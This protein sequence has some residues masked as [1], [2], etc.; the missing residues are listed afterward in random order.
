VCEGVP[1][2]V[3]QRGNYRQNIFEEDADREKYLELF[4]FYKEKFNIKLYAFCLMDN[5]VHFIV[6]PSSEKGLAQLFNCTHMRYSQYFNKKRAVN[7]HLWQ[8]RFYSCALDADHLYEALRYVELNPLR[9]GIINR[10]DAYNW[11]SMKEHLNG[12]GVIKLDDHK[13][14]IEIDD[15]RSYLKEKA[16]DEILQQLKGRTKNGRPAGN[17]SFIKKLEKKIGKAI[18]MHK[19]GRPFKMANK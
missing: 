13:H 5:H 16:D 12:K 6:E 10:I 9:A 1:Y 11:S 17:I 2:H 4:L 14:H 3:T 8:G 7:G 19:K 18:P 15:W